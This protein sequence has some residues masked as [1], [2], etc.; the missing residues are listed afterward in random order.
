M[1]S[2]KT[3]LGPVVCSC[4]VPFFRVFDRQLHDMTR[5]IAFDIGG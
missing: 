1:R 2:N 5:D 4:V 3:P